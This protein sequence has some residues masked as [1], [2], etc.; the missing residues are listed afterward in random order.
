MFIILS[1]R[2]LKELIVSKIAYF[3][4]SLKNHTTHHIDIVLLYIISEYFYFGFSIF[5]SSKSQM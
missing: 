1:S 4:K 3:Y 5:V 2:C